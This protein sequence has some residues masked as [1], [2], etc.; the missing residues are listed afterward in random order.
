MVQKNKVNQ[1]TEKSRVK[2]VTGIPAFKYSLK[3]SFTP[4]DLADSA[5]IRLATEPRRVRLPANVVDTARSSQRVLAFCNKGTTGL[6]KSTAGTFETILLT[7][8]EIM[9]KVAKSDCKRGRIK[10]KR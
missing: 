4:L 3:E 2:T 8:A 7:T 10:E 1:I 6:N 9:E 5:T